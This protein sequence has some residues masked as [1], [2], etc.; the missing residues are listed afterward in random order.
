MLVLMLEVVNQRLAERGDG[1][2]IKGIEYRNLRP[3]PV[4]KETKVCGREKE[5]GNIEVWVEIEGGL[6][7]RGTVTLE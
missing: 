2:R 4:G 7:V 5:D 6:A 3:V 1:K